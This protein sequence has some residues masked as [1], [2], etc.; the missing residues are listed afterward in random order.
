M[1]VKTIHSLSRKDRTKWDFFLNMELIEFLNTMALSNTL[2]VEYNEQMVRAKNFEEVVVTI[3][4]NK[5]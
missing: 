2:E 4:Q 3:L 5:L 1:W